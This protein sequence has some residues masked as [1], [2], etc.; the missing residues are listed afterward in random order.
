MEICNA[1]WNVELFAH[2]YI[3]VIRFLFKIYCAL[4]Y[5]CSKTC[6]PTIQ[7]LSPEENKSPT[8]KRWNKKAKLPFSPLHHY[9]ISTKGQLYY[10]TFWNNPTFYIKFILLNL[11]YRY[12]TSVADPEPQV[13]ASFWWSWSRNAMRLHLN[14]IPEV[15][16][17]IEVFTR[18]CYVAGKSSLFNGFNYCTVVCSATTLGKWAQA[19]G[20]ATHVLASFKVKIFYD[21]TIFTVEPR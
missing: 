4:L 19:F 10:G 13:A 5:F 21:N 7:F 12:L 2:L 9:L 6:H 8:K 16:F 20:S 11:R 18:F 1:R 17:L 3:Q 14:K 15:E